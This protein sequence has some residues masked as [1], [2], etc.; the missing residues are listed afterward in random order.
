MGSYESTASIWASGQ[1]WR[2]SCWGTFYLK[3][4]SFHLWKHLGLLIFRAAMKTHLFLWWKAHEARRD[5]GDC[6]PFVGTG[7]RGEWF[8]WFIWAAVCWKCVWEQWGGRQ[9]VSTAR[10]VVMLP[11]IL[12]EKRYRLVWG[13]TTHPSS[14]GQCY[15]VRMWEKKALLDWQHDGNT[16]VLQTLELAAR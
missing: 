16:V 1:R 5:A 10:T 11:E 8:Q 13:E 7:L 2:A 9:R 14:P 4:A 12:P 15:A 3:F 6:S